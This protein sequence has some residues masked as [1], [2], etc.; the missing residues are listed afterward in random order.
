MCQCL[1]KG[2]S[3]HHKH[4]K[5][6]KHHHISIVPEHYATLALACGLQ[7]HRAKEQLGPEVTYL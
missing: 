4:Y 1:N 3:K 7:Q 5:H 2:H 6:H